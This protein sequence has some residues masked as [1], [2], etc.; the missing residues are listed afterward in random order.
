MIANDSDRDRPGVDRY[1]R[2]Y[3]YA[4]SDD[5]QGVE[6]P[7]VHPRHGRRRP[8]GHRTLPVRLPQVR[9]HYVGYMSMFY[10]R[11]PQPIDIH[12]ATSRDGFNFTRVCRATPFIPSGRWGTTTSWRWPAPS[13]SQSS[14]TTRSTCTTPRSTFRTKRLIRTVRAG[15]EWRLVTFKRDRFASL[16]TGEFHSGPG[17]EHR[18]GPAR[19]RIVTKP[20]TVRHPRAVPECRHLGERIDTGRSADPRLAAD[21]RVYRTPGAG[22]PG[23]CPGPPGPVEGQRRREQA[24]GEGD[25]SQ[26]LHDSRAPVRNDP[27]RRGEKAERS[28]Q[29]IPR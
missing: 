17:D 4:E 11:R 9:R 5:L 13:P 29:R 22:C 20:F 28:R 6:E 15:S 25:S 7:P 3:A 19:C 1:N 10:L 8:A 27:D 26:V 2:S 12:L 23:G 21:S 18:T 24:P 16:E 14:S